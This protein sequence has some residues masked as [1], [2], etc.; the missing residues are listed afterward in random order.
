V[1]A[2]GKGRGRIT[3]VEGRFDGFTL[4]A[5]GAVIQ[6]DINAAEL[7]RIEDLVAPESSDAPLHYRITGV[8]NAFGSENALPAPALKVALTGSVQLVCQRCL[9]PFS[10][11][12]DQQTVVLLARNESELEKLDEED[13]DHEVILADVPL[14]AVALVEDE[15]VL[16]LPFVPRCPEDVCP[17]L[18][19]EQTPQEPEASEGSSPFEALAQLR[20]RP[21]LKS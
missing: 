20:S 14:D 4:A 2:E 8:G 3:R 10:Y 9:Q 15:L 13:A 5:R 1:S 21:P 6:G 7:T 19:G 11:D 16:T 18:S 17:A 12:I